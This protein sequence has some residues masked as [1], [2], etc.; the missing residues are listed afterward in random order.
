MTIQHA[1][2]FSRREFV[3]G[4][5]LAGT[6]GFLGVTA[7]PVTAEPPPETTTIRLIYDPDISA[8]CYAPQFV[9]EELLRAE[10]FTDVRYVRLVE[11]SEAKTLVT[12]QADLSAEFTGDLILA[13]DAGRPIVIL[14]GLHMGCLEL[15]GSAPIR[16][17]RD[18]RGKTVAVSALG[19][20]D[21]TFL[22][23]M[24]AY[25]GLDPRK[26]VNWVAHAP[27]DALRAF[28]EGQ[29]DAFMT[30]PPF[31]QE[32]RT[33]TAGHVIVKTA[34]DHPWSQYFC[35]MLAAHREFVRRHPIATK[36][37]LRAILKATDMCAAEPDRTARL[38]ADKGYVSRY[39]LVL[40][41]LQDVPYARWR[42][43][44]PE[45]TLRFYGL[46]LHE[47]G[48]IKS[49]PQKIIA[50]GTDWRFFNELKKE[51]KG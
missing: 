49:T 20:A 32:F 15:V 46:R 40:Q 37:A 2:P 19:G 13:S 24:V 47:I 26:D 35:C 18:L 5:G 48:M 39:D 11:G 17:L 12:G 22:A 34:T 42:D 27:A 3:A 44:S 33:R 10:G 43:F 6:A 1:R 31:A 38:L 50:Q 23:V 16:T 45:D 21:Q 36:R 4:L 25:V 51:L 7:P 29:F 8:V 41:F 30:F 9:A 14:A 28:T